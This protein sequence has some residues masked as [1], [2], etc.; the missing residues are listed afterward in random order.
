MIEK[1]KRPQ[2]FNNQEMQIPRNIQELMQR[3]DLDSND[4]RDYLDF[5]IT[6]VAYKKDVAGD[7]NKLNDKNIITAGLNADISFSSTEDYQLFNIPLTKEMYKVGNKLNIKNGKILIPTGVSKILVS[8]QCTSNGTLNTYGIV[9]KK[10]YDE[11]YQTYTAPPSQTFNSLSLSP[12]L[13]DV[14]EGDLIS[15]NYYLNNVGHTR[16]VLS[17]GGCR[18]YLTV[19]VIK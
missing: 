1:I 9:I 17:D 19:E 15:L 12:G 4:I 6:Q 11:A 5:L 14:V 13:I 16:S 2:Q 7:I 8:A 3:Y 10:N 18:T